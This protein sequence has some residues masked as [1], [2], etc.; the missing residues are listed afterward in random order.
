[1]GKT[2]DLF[3]NIGD[4]RGTFHARVVLIKERRARYVL[5]QSSRNRSL[6]WNGRCVAI[7]SWVVLWVTGKRVSLLSVRGPGPAQRRGEQGCHRVGP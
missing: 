5:L 1:M 3:K 7:K 6:Q 4:T 2:R